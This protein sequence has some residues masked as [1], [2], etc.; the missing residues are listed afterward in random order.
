MRN[1][2]NVRAKIVL[3]LLLLFAIILLFLRL[4]QVRDEYNSMVIDPIMGILVDQD[5]T[6]NFN[7]VSRLTLRFQK[8]VDELEDEGWDIPANPTAID[9]WALELLGMF[10][11]EGAVLGTKVP[12]QLE[13]VPWID[14]GS[15]NHVGGRSDCQNY[16]ILN[17]RYINPISEWFNSHTWPITIAHEL[18]HVQQTQRLCFNSDRALIE[19]TAQIVSWEVMSSLANSGNRNALKIMIYEMRDVALSSARAQGTDEQ[20]MNLIRE[21]FDSPNK[22]AR[23]E[24]SNRVW[25]DRRDELQDILTK[26]SQTPLDMIFLERE[27]GT[28]YGLALDNADRTME[29]DDLIYFL[30]HAEEML[31]DN[32]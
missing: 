20:F 5:E 15:H 9:L 22:L 4:G 1:W 14:A 17:F 6:M 24:K 21:M 32:R 30:S 26:Y 27:F 28:V 12:T 7:E 29:I 31:A 16:A 10:P 3:E 2:I 8:L 19:N 11:Y 18:A 23:I 25:E 13:A